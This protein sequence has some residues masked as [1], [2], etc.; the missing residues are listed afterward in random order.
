LA[1]ARAEAKPRTGANKLAPNEFLQNFDPRQN[2]GINPL[3]PHE[4]PVHVS[5]G[6]PPAKLRKAR[7]KWAKN[8]RNAMRPIP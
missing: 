1:R 3:N 4:I 5:E 2:V 8:A 6:N 7:E